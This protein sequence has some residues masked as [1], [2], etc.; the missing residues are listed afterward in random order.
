M[1]RQPMMRVGGGA[2]E[3]IVGGRVASDREVLAAISGFKWPDDLQARPPPRASS[4][5]FGERRESRLAPHEIGQPPNQTG[6]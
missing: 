5:Q 1:R 2:E 3:G 4:S 6:R